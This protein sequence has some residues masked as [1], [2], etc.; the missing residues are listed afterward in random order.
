MRHRTV[1]ASLL[2]LCAAACQRD[3]PPAEAAAPTQAPAAPA[4]VT[5]Q[6]RI[7]AD[8]RILADDDMQGREAGTPGYDKAADYVAKR[9]RA[10]GLLPAGD[11]GSYFQQVPLLR[12]TRLQDGARLAVVHPQRTVELRFKE[13]FLPAPSYDAASS[14]VTAPAV[15][16]G[17]GVHA[18][19]LEH[20]DFAGLDLRGKVAVLFNGAPARFGNDQRAFHS[21]GREKLRALAERGAVGAV[22]V[23]T[24]QDEARSPWQRG[25][26]AWQKPG[27]R[28]RGA[29]GKGI[30]TFP[31]LKVVASVSAAAAD[32]LFEGSGRFASQLFGA[33][34]DGSLR[35]FALPVTLTLASRTRVE[36]VDSRNVVGRI[37]GADATLG[38]EHIVY[39]AHLDHVGVGAPVNGDAIYNGAIDNALGVAIMLEA[40][41]ELASATPAP[42]R[43]LV[44]VAVTAEEKGL[45]GA[46]WFATHP[47]VDGPLVANI[48]LDM[49]V[50]LAPST[51][52]VPIGVEHSSLKDALD[53]AAKEV[54]V[55]LSPDPFP[56]EVIFVRSDQYPFIRAGIPAVYLINGVVSA[57]GKRDPKLAFGKFLGEHYHQPSD[58]VDLPIAWDDAARLAR[59]NARIGRLVGDAAQRPAWNAGDFF[60]DRFATPAA[61]AATVKAKDKE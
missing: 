17:Y 47:T 42:K 34:G 59:L 51:D 26:D 27:M 50:L 18:P 3:T 21:S 12:A 20:D 22:F 13:Q 56:E 41:R 2:L 52:V 61:P 5:A 4:A 25:A 10:L 39:S 9:M 38:N 40:A 37:A 7:A 24:A 23:N 28:L 8:V 1:L 33:A 14:E 32:L 30:D 53:V 46:E 48:N 16:V 35:G 19:E 49:P 31:Q 36:P 15:F 60:G 11:A 6:G 57:D 45:L 55:K 54:G 58:Q 29:D 43:S 44:F